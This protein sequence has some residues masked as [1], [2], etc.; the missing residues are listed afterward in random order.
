MGNYLLLIGS[1]NA[2]NKAFRSKIHIHKKC[3]T[4]NAIFPSQK[5]IRENNS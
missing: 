1:C 2:C 4:C 3:E 5:F